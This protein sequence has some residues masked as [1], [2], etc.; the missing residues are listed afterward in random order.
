MRAGGASAPRGLPVAAASGTVLWI[1]VFLGGFVFYEPA[2]YELFLAVLVPFWLLCGLRV[3]RSIG[4]LVLLMAVFMVGG[5]LAV[6]Q[7]RTIDKEPIYL[8]VSGFLA[9]SACFYAAVIAGDPERRVGLVV[10]AWI[11]A[12]VATATLGLLGYFGLAPDGLFTLYGRAAGGFQDPNVFG[13][14]LAFPFGI[15]MHRVMLRPLSAMTVLRACV[16]LYVLVGIFLSFSRAAWGLSVV[17][18]LLSLLV[19]FVNERRVEA[20]L[21]IVG[22]ALAGMLGAAALLAAM[23]AIPEVASLFKER[24]QVVQEYDAAHHGR[25]A[26]HIIGFNMMLER[27]LGLG[28]LEFGKLYG[29]DEHNVY[30][31]ALTTYGWPGFAALVTLTVWT[32]SAGFPLLFR[33]SPYRDVAQVVYC[34][35]LG[36]MLMAVVIDIDHWRHAYLLF[37]MIWGLVA[38]DRRRR[39]ERLRARARPAYREVALGAREV[40]AIGT[41]HCTRPAPSL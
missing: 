25:F 9:L 27:Q 39:G 36:H 34:V 16:A 8:A 21:R 5:L 13:P 3:P 10:N 33:P 7:S 23:L 4:P 32:F 41:A 11:S 6:T 37:G 29:Q 20:R 26:R 30:L 35:L 2:P 19:S 31:K 22:L 24:A 15:L 40:A 38:V 28:A 18:V 1:A 12:A 17:T 14:F